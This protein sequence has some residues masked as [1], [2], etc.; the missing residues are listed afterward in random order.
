MGRHSKADDR[1]EDL[2]ARAWRAVRKFDSMTYGLTLFARAITGDEKIEVRKHATM[3]ATDGKVI[4]IAPPIELGDDLFHARR[5]VCQT[6]D[7]D[8]YRLVCDACDAEETVE[9]RV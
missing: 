6:R 2:M 9:V 7:E 3:T 5:E 8:T 4:W 1:P